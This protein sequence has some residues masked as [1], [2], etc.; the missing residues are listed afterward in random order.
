MRELEVTLGATRIETDKWFPLLFGLLLWRTNDTAWL[1][2]NLRH[3]W[4]DE[5]RVRR[6]CH[7]NWSSTLVEMSV[8]RN[9]TLSSDE[10]N[11]DW[12]SNGHLIVLMHLIAVGEDS[13]RGWWVVLQWNRCRCAEYDLRCHGRCGEVRV[14]GMHVRLVGNMYGC[15][16]WS[17]LRLHTV[18]HLRSVNRRVMW[19]QLMIGHR[20]AGVHGAVR[21]R[22]VLLVFQG[23]RGVHR[24]EVWASL[25]DVWRHCS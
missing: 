8:S 23:G 1:L 4:Y 13:T 7:L 6:H 3:L 2:R 17:S 15:N 9:T 11:W 16:L 20:R 14:L 22:G 21:W 18:R 10:L 24:Q 19:G 25:I 5:C 12:E